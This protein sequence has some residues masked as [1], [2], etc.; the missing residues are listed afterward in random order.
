M[1]NSKSRI[2]NPQAREAMDQFKYQAAQDF[3][4]NTHINEIL[5]SQ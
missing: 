4:V 3:D 5:H 1:A 2:M